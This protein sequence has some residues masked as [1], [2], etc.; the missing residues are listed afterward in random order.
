MS[1][2]A[3]KTCHQQVLSLIFQLV[4][5]ADLIL[6][7]VSIIP[8][9]LIRSFSTFQHMKTV[10]VYFFLFFGIS[11]FCFKWQLG[12][13]WHGLLHGIVQN[14]WSMLSQRDLWI[15]QR[16]SYVLEWKQENLTFCT[17]MDTFALVG[18]LHA[19]QN[20]KGIVDPKMRIPSFTQTRMAFFCSVEYKRR[21]FFQLFF[22]FL[23][24]IQWKSIGLSSSKKT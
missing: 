9:T 23:F 20:L 4:C 11:W 13:S 6:F 21:Y 7:T 3:I 14:W 16:A 19:L 24:R 1:I 17:N 5:N 18:H 2:A 12:W 15:F 22:S 10:Y 8:C